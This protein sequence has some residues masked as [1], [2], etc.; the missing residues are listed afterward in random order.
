[1]SQLGLGVNLAP[2]LTCEP[3]WPLGQPA[4]GRLPFAPMR[5]RFPWLLPVLAL[6]LAGVT[7]A[8]ISTPRNLVWLQ[9][10]QLVQLLMHQL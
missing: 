1:M 7:Q 3:T 5:T 2:E 9:L 10:V 8:W 4:W 6:L